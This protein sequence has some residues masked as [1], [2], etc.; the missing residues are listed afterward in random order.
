MAPSGTPA[1]QF[2][3]PGFPNPFGGPFVSFQFIHKIDTNIR[4]VLM[5]LMDTNEKL[6]LFVSFACISILVSHFRGNDY[7][8][9]AS[10]SF[11]LL[12]DMIGRFY[13]R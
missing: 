10:Q 12:F 4:M 6:V 9:K 7:C 11:W 3:G 2:A 1:H 5:I 8:D 13:G